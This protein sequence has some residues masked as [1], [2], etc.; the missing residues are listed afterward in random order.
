MQLILAV[1]VNGLRDKL[2]H[3][4]RPMYIIAIGLASIIFVLIAYFLLFHHPR[5][6]IRP[7]AN[8]V[9]IRRFI[10]VR[11]SVLVYFC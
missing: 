7:L 4:H 1:C 2:P 6:T 8:P 3:R 5:D 11:Y 9:R 10:V